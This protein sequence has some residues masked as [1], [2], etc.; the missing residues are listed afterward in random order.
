MK[1]LALGDTM[2]VIERIHS[3]SGNEIPVVLRE[4]THQRQIGLRFH[5]R[6]EKVG[7]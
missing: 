5:N 6:K 2:A 3:M 1:L 7:D 4:E